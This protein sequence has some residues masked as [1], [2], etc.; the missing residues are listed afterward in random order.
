M[1]LS[2]GLTYHSQALPQ[3]PSRDTIPLIYF[4]ASKD[5]F[6]TTNKQ[7]WLVRTPDWRQP[8]QDPAL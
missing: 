2:L 4:N 5:V 8:G 1:D 3:P 6:G 7:V